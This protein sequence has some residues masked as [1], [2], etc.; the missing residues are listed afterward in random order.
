MGKS[1]TKKGCEAEIAERKIES[2]TLRK[3]G[4]SY[5]DIGIKLNISRQTAYNDVW[6]TI[7]ELN[8]QSKKEGKE[9]LQLEIDK[10]NDYLK[11]LKWRIDI[12]DRDAMMMALKI[13]ERFCKLRGLEVEKVASTTPDGQKEAA[14]IIVLPEKNG[15][16][17]NGGKKK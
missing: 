5:R 4:Y 7:A 10:L 2:F 8:E 17:K 15:N 6:D 9:Y 1:G 16:G 11:I 12:G 14:G 13:H 3:Q